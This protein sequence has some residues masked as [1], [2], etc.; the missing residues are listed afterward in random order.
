M[1][2]CYLFCCILLAGCTQQRPSLSSDNAVV[3]DTLIQK[4]PLNIPASR[5]ELNWSSLLA[6]ME[7]LHEIPAEQ[8][9]ITLKNIKEEALK[10]NMLPW[11]EDWN[12]KPIRAR[13]NVFLTHASIAA[14]QR[15]GDAALEAQSLAINKMKTSWDIFADQISGE[16]MLAPFD[17]TI[18]QPI[19]KVE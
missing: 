9:A 18:S 1:R 17:P 14:D 13:F 2:F 5:Q 10:L 11:P 12:A 6:L 4:D 19:R 15:S 8:R 3:I 16:A 7:S